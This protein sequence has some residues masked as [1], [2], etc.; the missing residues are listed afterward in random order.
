[1]KNI[2]YATGTRNA[3]AGEQKTARDSAA[4]RS[5]AVFD[6]LVRALSSL[7]LGIVLLV[8]VLL[9][10]MVGMLV[11]Q[12]NMQ[13]FREYYLKLS[14][15]QQIVYGRLGL[16]DIYHSWYFS[17]LL[18]IVGLNIV[19]S[20]LDYWPRAWSYLSR[21]KLTAT[22]EYARTRTLTAEASAEGS[23]E[24]VAEAV[25]AA[26]RAKGVRG[27][28]TRDGARYTLLAQRGAWNR[29]GAYFVHI[30]LIIIFFGGFLTSRYGVGGMMEITPGQ[31][32]DTFL[33]V[34]YGL[35]GQRVEEVR[36]PFAVECMDI[37]QKLIDQRGGLEPTNTRDW[38]SAGVIRDG[39][40][41]TPARVQMNAPFDY[42]GYRFFQSGF[43]PTGSARQI[44]I[45]V[46][47]NGTTKEVTI[48]R[49]G[50]AEVEGM[51]LVTYANFFP[52]YVSEGGAPATASG[53]YN[54]PAAELL[55]TSPDGYTRAALAVNETLAR[56]LYAEKKAGS[57]GKQQRAAEKYLL[58]DFEKVGS[59]HTLSVQYDPGR[60]PVYAGF[61]L[62][63]VSLFGVFFS[64][65]RR[66]WAVV[67]PA[68]EGTKIYFGGDTNRNKPALERFFG[69][70]VESATAEEKD[71]QS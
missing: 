32:T 17:L 46:E 1:M 50:S 16:F 71:S 35:D 47:A 69:R 58:K 36:L 59:S 11:M 38:M 51:G 13:G 29:L 60:T 37:Q 57:D 33:K 8:V 21:P 56:E 3:R 49:G 24:A 39:G 52:D 12:Q 63:T 70:L 18:I 41:E 40:R 26:W 44:K 66:V 6:R 61:L 53:E 65:H 68:G 25:A 4:T 42:A 23:A 67:E 30:A 27:R 64:S 34:E 48:Q 31:T 5:V 15:S 9:L 62:L 14:P 28:V 10:C 45:G 7:R 2:S 20:S 54:N 19:L 43:E 55:I 22:P